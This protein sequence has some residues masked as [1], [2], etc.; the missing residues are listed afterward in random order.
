MSDVISVAKVKNYDMESLKKQGEQ[1][2]QPDQLISNNGFYPDISLLEV[3]N[4]MRID[5]TVTN[6]RLTLALVEAIA[7]VNDELRP[8]QQRSKN[9]DVFSLEELE[10]EQINGTSIVLQRYKRAVY[11][12][13]VANLYERYRAYDSTKEGAEKGEEFNDSVDDLKR[14]GMFA[15]RDILKQNRI[16]VELI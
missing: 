10:A 4:V 1:Q 13:T 6:A 14:D 7:F 9:A 12:F 16:N 8:F 11:C 3:R 2:A 15:I 5:G